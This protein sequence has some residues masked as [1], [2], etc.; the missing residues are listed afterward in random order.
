MSN[1][2]TFA[3]ICEN[4]GID[5]ETNRHHF[6][7]V[8]ADPGDEKGR[9]T[10]EIGIVKKGEEIQRLNRIHSEA[11]THFYDIETHIIFQGYVCASS[12]DFRF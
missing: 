11:G 4:W 10:R 9:L 3:E 6:E 5:A 1:K 7:W 12:M 2:V 8:K